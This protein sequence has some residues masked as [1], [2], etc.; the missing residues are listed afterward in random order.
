LIRRFFVA[1][2]L[3]T[4][5]VL[6]ATAAAPA[7]AVGG[8][9]VS[10]GGNAVTTTSLSQRAAFGA[11]R[12]AST[13]TLTKVGER[14]RQVENGRSGTNYFQ[15]VAQGQVFRNGAWRLEVQNSSRSVQ[16]PNDLRNFVYT[17]AQWIY[18]HGQTNLTH[19][20]VVQA[21][22]WNNSGTPNFFGDDFTVH[23]VNFTLTCFP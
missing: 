23:R 12:T 17:P 14:V 18:T 21:R 8:A 4:G 7:G 22:W 19:R 16:F 10:G 11:S 2:C 3:L 5:G 15:Q 1:L 20:I 6:F 9:S 13:C